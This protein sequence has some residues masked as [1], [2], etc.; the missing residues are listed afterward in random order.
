MKKS[1][2]LVSLFLS[3][4]TTDFAY[5]YPPDN[6]A[7]LYY[8][9]M[10]EFE[11]PD[12]VVWEQICNLPASSE[13]ASK[14][15]K[16]FVEKRKNDFTIPELEIASEIKYCDWG[17]DYSKGYS[18]R[19]PGLSQ[20]KNFAFLLLAD[21]AIAAREG[22]ISTAIKK[23]L[24]VRRIAH[25]RSNDATIV[26]WLMGGGMTA[27]SNEA[28]RFMLSTYT[29]NEGV[30]VKLKEQLL[31]EPY[32]PLSVREPLIG[33]R[34]LFVCEMP[35]MTLDRFVSCLHSEAVVKRAS[36]IFERRDPELIKRT[37]KY[38]ERSYDVIL[39]LLDK[40]YVQAYNGYQK[41]I[42]KVDDDSNSGNDEAFLVAQFYPA[43]SSIYNIAVRRQTEYNAILNALDVY[44]IFQKTG[45]LPE[46]LDENSYPDC[47]S[48]KPFEYLVTK[49][50]F[51]LRCRQE[52]LVAKKVQEYV[53]K[54][55]K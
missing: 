40:P 36:I 43:A 23:N 32:R 35:D 47:F 37:I 54:L 1:Y 5:A 19:L 49:E 14:E 45:K 31:Q 27:K 44:I 11:I 4:L 28:L 39:S 53:F 12:K 52:D 2:L 38:A 16:A 21:G 7:V 30:L 48:G 41:E 10:I 55:P 24:V 34:N 51:T 6:A 17:L 50:G 9:L 46:K 33:E 18:M 26:P 8:G 25:H 42:Q 29:V 22:D 20:I 13:P 15:V 3:L